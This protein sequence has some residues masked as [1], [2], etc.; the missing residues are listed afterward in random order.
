MNELPY[1]IACRSANKNGL[2]EFHETIG[3]VTLHYI[4]CG[5][6]IPTWPPA[7]EIKWTAWAMSRNPRQLS[8]GDVERW[9]KLSSARNAMHDKL[10][11]A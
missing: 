8:H 4:Q 11:Y 10:A 6:L 7:V 1:E 3:T 9:N 5:T 2:R